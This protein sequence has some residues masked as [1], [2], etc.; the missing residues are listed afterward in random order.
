MCI[1]M[2]EGE[3]ETLQNVPDHLKTEEMCK[4]AVHRDPNA[5]GHVPDHTKT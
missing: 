3:P 4:E 1:K 2:V 5:L